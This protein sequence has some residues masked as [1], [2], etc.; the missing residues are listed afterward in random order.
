MWG[1]EEY[2]IV[3]SLLPGQE[4][5]AASKQAPAKMELSELWAV[6]CGCVRVRVLVLV[7]VLGV[8][9]RCVVGVVGV[10]CLVCV[11]VSLSLSQPLLF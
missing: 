2:R 10:V 1:W 7:C 8:T 4:V 11:Y 9:L 6:G 3:H 5:G